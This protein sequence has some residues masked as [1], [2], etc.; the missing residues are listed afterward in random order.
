MKQVKGLLVLVMALALIA[1]CA[2]MGDVKS[3]PAP[4]LDRIQERG[5]LVVG[6]A[7]SMP[8]FNMVTR[9]G[10]L[11]GLDID[12]ARSIAEGMGVRIKFQTMPFSELLPALAAGKVD[13][14]I[15]S[16]TMTPKR[17][18]KV[19]FVGPYFISG[20]GFLTKTETIANAG[21]AVEVNSPDVKMAALEGSTSEDFVKN[22]LNKTQLITVK[23]YEEGVI[24][25][26][27]GEA[28]A[29]VADYPVCLVSIARYPDEGLLSVVAPL[30]YE[31]LGIAVPASDPHLVNW[32]GNF[33][34]IL[35]GSDTL[36]EL[37]DRWFADASWL[38]RLP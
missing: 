5:E 15:S 3:T 11:I 23:D 24:K 36:E 7:G 33:L 8:P 25:V 18:L 27:D 16:M 4:V 29:M 26:L 28:H 10:E 35:E 32:L 22:V 31:P 20:K 19:A 13:M 17:N 30:S 9:E 2:H 34:E 14:I 1:G 12:L 21:E 38:L 37:R 6:T